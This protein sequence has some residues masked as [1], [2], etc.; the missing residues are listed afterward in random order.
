MISKTTKMLACLGAVACASTKPA[1]GPSEGPVPVAVTARAPETVPAA[2]APV[3][4]GF[5]ASYERVWRA[6]PEAFASLGITANVADTST[7]AMGF[8]GMVRR[9]IGHEPVSKY[10]SCGRTDQNEMAA[11]LYDVSAVLATQVGRS[12]NGRIIVTTKARATAK[13]A[14]FAHDNVF[15]TSTGFF[16]SAIFDSLKV[17]LATV[18]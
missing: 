14:S 3:S 11:D 8:A 4:R 18:K 17:K 9:K 12:A 15:C 16:E 1:P 6:L 5:M 10:F 2:T 13:S 7:R